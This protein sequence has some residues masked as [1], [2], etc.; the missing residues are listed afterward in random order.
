MN[1]CEALSPCNVDFMV[2][3]VIFQ[4][5]RCNGFKDDD[6]QKRLVLDFA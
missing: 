6:E 1:I 4:I 5:V 2:Q 3:I